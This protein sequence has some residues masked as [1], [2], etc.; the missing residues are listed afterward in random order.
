MLPPLSCLWLLRVQ[1]SK[2]NIN[3]LGAFAVLLVPPVA[4]GG[5]G[6][7]FGCPAPSLL[8]LI[9]FLSCCLLLC[10]TTYINFSVLVGFH[11]HILL[12]IFRL[13]IQH[14]ILSSSGRDHIIYIVGWFPGV[15]YYI[16]S[17]PGDSSKIFFT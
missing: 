10:C 15:I 16:G 4:P 14:N 11:W 2:N 9:A 3:I 7:V 17:G 1:T 12:K 6:G 13:L 5:R 8:K